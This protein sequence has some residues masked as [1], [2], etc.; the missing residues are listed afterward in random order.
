MHPAQHTWQKGEFR[1][2]EMAANGCAVYALVS[3]RVFL[4][5]GSS[6]NV[7][8]Q[9]DCGPWRDGVVKGLDWAWRALADRRPCGGADVVVLGFHGME[10][11]TTADS[12]AYAAAQALFPALDLEPKQAARYEAPGKRFTFPD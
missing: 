10:V 11:D 3:L 7:R 6:L 4:Y 2:A 9:C 1:L 12:A 5:E 8:C